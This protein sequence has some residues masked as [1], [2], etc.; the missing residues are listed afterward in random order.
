[1]FKSKIGV[2]PI[3]Y[4]IQLRITKAQILLM[5][6]NETIKK[7]A[8]MVGFNNAG[9]FST[10]FHKTVGVTPANFRMSS[11]RNY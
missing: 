5:N 7:V 6:T 4:L 11:K 3:N 9:Y 2:S 8:L 1:V 10:L